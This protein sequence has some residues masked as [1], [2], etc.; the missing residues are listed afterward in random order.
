MEDRETH[1]GDPSWIFQVRARGFYFRLVARSHCRTRIRRVFPLA[2]IV[3]CW[4]FTLHRSRLGSLSPMAVLGIQVRVRI[5]VRQCERFIGKENSRLSRNTTLFEDISADSM[6]DCSVE[7]HIYSSYMCRCSSLFHICRCIHTTH[8]FTEL[9]APTCGLS[10]V[11]FHGFFHVNH[12]SRSV[13]YLI[14]GIVR[15]SLNSMPSSPSGSL[16]ITFEGTLANT[17]G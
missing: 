17:M 4:K 8:R 5:W 15:C 12:Q 7:T 14:R 10:T 6:F 16:G 9:Y 11:L 3:K 13:S 1:R 2:T